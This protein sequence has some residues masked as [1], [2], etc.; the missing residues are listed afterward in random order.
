MYRILEV[1]AGTATPRRCTS[2]S[3]AHEIALSS[4]EIRPLG[5]AIVAAD[6]AAQRIEG[7]HGDHQ[8]GV[9]RSRPAEREG[10]DGAVTPASERFHRVGSVEQ[11]GGRGRAIAVLVQ[12]GGQPFTFSWSWRRSILP[13]LL[14]GNSSSTVISRGTL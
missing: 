13:V 2:T 3:S 1:R 14:R 10:Q 7:R 9:L 4:K 5:R 12:D 6:R 8:R 11:L